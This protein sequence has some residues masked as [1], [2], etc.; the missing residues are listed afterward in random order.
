MKTV[1]NHGMGEQNDNPNKC[2]NPWFRWLSSFTG[3]RIR[4][5]SHHHLRDE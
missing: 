3:G 2:R 1:M 5:G 4:I